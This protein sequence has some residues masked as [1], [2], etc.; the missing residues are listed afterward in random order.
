MYDTKVLYVDGENKRVLTRGTGDK[1]SEESYVGYDLLLGCDGVRSPVRAAVLQSHRDFECEVSGIFANFKAVHIDCAASVQQDA[2]HILPAALP[3]MNGIAL[4]E[5]GGKLNVSFAHA[6]DTKI[7]KVLYSEDPK[8]VAAY[9]KKHFK[10]FE[11]DYDDWAQQW[12][13][14]TW[15]QTGQVHCNFYHSS[16]LSIIIMGDAAHATSPALGMGM[17]T[18]LADASV[19]DDLMNTFGDDLEKVLPAF[20]KLRVKEGNALAY[21]SYYNQPFDLALAAK[22]RK[23]AAWQSWLHK[24]FPNCVKD[25]PMKSISQGRLL[26]EVYKDM[27]ELGWLPM[28]RESNDQVRREWFERQ[29]A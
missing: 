22:M 29:T 2:V 28:V 21:L 3:S 11:V 24:K 6:F 15:N 23:K 14:Q 19:L 20:S 7:D 8:E 1:E 12:V 18:A 26:S 25:D 4:P 9:L 13:S 10:C 27:V 16:K 5:T 17:N